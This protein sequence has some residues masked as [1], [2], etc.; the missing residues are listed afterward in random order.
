[1][2]LQTQGQKGRLGALRI[3]TEKDLKEW[4]QRNEENM[5]G[6]WE[7]IEG[8]VDSGA[9]DTV[10]NKDTV[11]FIPINETKR[12]KR[13]AFWTTADGNHVYNEG[14]N[15]IEGCT[16]QG[17][18]TGMPM[19]VGDV[20]TTLFSIGRMKEAGNL[21][22][23]GLKE[24]LAVVNWKTGKTLCKGG[25][26]VIVDENTGIT[27]SIDDNGKE[28]TKKIWVKILEPEEE[29]KNKGVPEGNKGRD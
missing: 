7:V 10:T 9:V 15:F 3:L 16:G 8:V 28:Y 18:P 19:Q 1:M 14:E 27:T 5:R 17:T 2:R 22:V 20:S 11:K 21:V 23:F 26:N 29:E 24:E 12:S 6:K 4:K 25:D 13:E